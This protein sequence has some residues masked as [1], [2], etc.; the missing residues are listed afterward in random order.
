MIE[1]MSTLTFRT[2]WNPT[3]H[4][5][6][7]RSTVVYR[8]KH[9]RMRVTIAKWSYKYGGHELLMKWCVTTIGLASDL[10]TAK[11]APLRRS[12]TQ[13]PIRSK[14]CEEQNLMKIIGSERFLN[15]V[16]INSHTS[17][18]KPQMRSKRR[19]ADSRCD[20]Q[21]DVRADAKNWRICDNI[22]KEAMSTDQLGSRPW[23]RVYDKYFNGT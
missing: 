14:N 3:A 15:K 8:V 4:K 6:S 7:L 16:N 13:K 18:E 1:G 17:L 22:T 11:R 23:N 10:R 9:N 20:Q 21:L 5:E 2:T 12:T 19:P